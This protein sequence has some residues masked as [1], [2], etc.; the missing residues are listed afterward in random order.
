[1]R[2]EP[3]GREL[4]LLAGQELLRRGGVGAVKLQALTEELGL[5]TGSFYHHF[6]GM[7]AYLDDLASYYG[8]EQTHQ[9]IDGIDDTD[10]RA[11]LRK[12]DT[13]SR[14]DRMYTLDAAMRD[15]GGSNALAAEAVHNSDEI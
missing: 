6:A 5:T 7:R 10:P 11:R 3:R 12:L 4:W 15:W 2:D 9:K 8:A 1:M 14:D 13:V